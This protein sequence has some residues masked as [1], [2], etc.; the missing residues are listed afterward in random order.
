MVLPPWFVEGYAEL[1]SSFRISKDRVVILGDLPNG[2]AMSLD[3]HSWI[4]MERLL[5]VKHTDA[6]YRTEKLMPQFYGEAWALVHMLVFDDKTLRTPTYRYL[7]DMDLGV[8]EPQAFKSAFPFDKAGLD[9]AVRSLLQRGRIHILKWTL[10]AAVSV[11]QVPITRVSAAQADAEFARLLF[12]L[13]KPNDVVLPLAAAALKEAPADPAIR[14][15]EARI[16]AHAGD[17][18]VD[19]RDLATSLATG[20]AGDAGLRTDVAAALIT[21]ISADGTLKQAVAILDDLVHTDRPPI[22]A[23][24]L[25]VD[26]GARTGVEPARLREV[27]EKASVRVPHNTRLLG[28][29]AWVSR[30]LSDKARARDYYTRIMLVSADPD[31]RLRAQ[32]EADSAELQDDPP[33]RH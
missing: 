29:L 7:R 24:M 31:E 9:T 32:K 14:A 18:D 22:E 30:M 10:P 12:R 13:N 33:P 23:I 21:P 28:Y 26:A 25:W 27:L 19:V 6:E 1:F 8:Q 5:A 16:A 20:A 15:L 11:D 2:L 17:P 3:R 4:P